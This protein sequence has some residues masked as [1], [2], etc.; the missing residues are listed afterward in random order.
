MYQTFYAVEMGMSEN[1]SL[2]GYA[3]VSFP[4]NSHIQTAEGGFINAP[5]H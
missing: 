5:N 3:T 2:A 1:W 4:K